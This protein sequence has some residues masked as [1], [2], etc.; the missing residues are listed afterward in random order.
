MSNLFILDVGNTN[1]VAGYFR[2]NHLVYRFR[3]ITDRNIKAR[4]YADMIKS[5]M[6]EAGF[7]LTEI[8]NLAISSV[9][10]S[11]QETL[12]KLALSHLK[13]KPFYVTPKIK[14]NF[15]VKIE[16]P[17]ELGADLI[18]S[19][20]A[21]VDKYSGP[22]III[23]MGSATTITAI[24]EK[25]EFLGGAI[26]P[27][28]NITASAFKSTV[29]HLPEI[30]L[31]P[32]PSVIGTNTVHALQAGIFTGYGWMV[33]GLVNEMKAELGKDVKVIATGGLS[34]LFR[35]HRALSFIHDPDLVLEG[36]KVLHG[37]NCRRQSNFT[38]SREIER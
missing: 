30:E 16:N 20:A 17:E 28:L 7:S 38:E 23:D 34:F 18:A 10:P 36:I 3:L 21:A 31:A 9:V 35:E 24:N 13:A 27:G 8:Q 29:P 1:I 19:A 22:C 15:T 6:S 5:K 26:S 25:C 2:E 33:G 12:S 32:P 11:M 4:A 37:L 14:L